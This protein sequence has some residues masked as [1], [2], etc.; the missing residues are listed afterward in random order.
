MN[1]NKVADLRVEKETLALA[2][3]CEFCEIFK[4]TFKNTTDS[5][6]LWTTKPQILYPM[7]TSANPW[8]SNVFKGF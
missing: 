2:F 8:F 5:G 4:N 3:S 1:F 7:K 6:H